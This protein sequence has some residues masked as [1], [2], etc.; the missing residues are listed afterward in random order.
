MKKIAKYFFQGLLYI[1]P[2]AATFYVLYKAVR[3]ADSLFADVPQLQF[4]QNIPGAGIVIILFLVTLIGYVGQKLITAPIASFFGNLMRKV[5]LVNMI[6]TAIRDLMKAFVGEKR[7]F[8]KPVLICLDGFGINHRIG[9]LTQEDLSS[10][11]ITDK[12]AVYVPC[13]Y[14]F[15]GD[16]MIVPASKVTSL[17]IP[18][19][20]AMK[21]SVSGG[22]SLS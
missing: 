16:M 6:Y 3:I 4:T 2:L 13:S 1:V 14:S 17:N 18:A 5:P 9:F 12:V 21:L 19:A 22:V 8:D 7:K 20:D 11:G 15:M 10:L